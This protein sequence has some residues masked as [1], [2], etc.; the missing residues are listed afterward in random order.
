MNL[1][2]NS[3]LI[4]LIK[5]IIFEELIKVK[6]SPI[7]RQPSLKKEE[8]VLKTFLVKLQ[9]TLDSGLF[10]LATTF[11]LLDSVIT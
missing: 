9:A 8:R 7:W 5:I 4:V 10:G 2:V 3:I 1:K 11:M 6:V